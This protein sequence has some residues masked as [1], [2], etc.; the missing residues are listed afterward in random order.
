MVRY[1]TALLLVADELTFLAV[2]NECRKR[3]TVTRA[4]SEWKGSCV[5][6]NSAIG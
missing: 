4:K 5:S 6:S 3:I 1:F 2:C